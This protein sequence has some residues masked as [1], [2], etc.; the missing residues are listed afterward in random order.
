MKTI[1]KL[2][3]AVAAI[4]LGATE[5]MA[6]SGPYQYFTL[7]PCRVVDTRNANA[8]NG[9]PALGTLP[10]SFQMRGNCGIPL[11]AKAISAN[12][13]VVY[14]TAWSWLTV[15]PS[16]LQIPGTATINYDQNSTA[17]G[18]G[19]ILGLSTNTLDITVQNAGGSCHL[20]IDVTGYYQ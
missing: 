15:W 4:S 10:R 17:I 16:N 6:Q 13:T 19:A 8:T 18:N 11:S 14:P 12:V 9:G 7:S 3:L 20:V 5:A 2:A 1:F